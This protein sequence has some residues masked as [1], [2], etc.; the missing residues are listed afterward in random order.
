M[1]VLLY[2]FRWADES[3]CEFQASADNR[4]GR[5]KIKIGDKISIE[6]KSREKK[7]AGSIENGIWKACPKNS[8]GKSKCDYCR[9]I[10]GNFVYTAFD[11]FDQS[12]LGAGDLD[13]ISDT[14][15]I[16]LAF[17]AENLIKVGVSKNSRKNL[18]QIEQG[19]LA[20][21]FV[22]E[23]PDGIAARQIETILR[24]SGLADKIQ[25]AQK[26]KVFLSD[27]SAEEIAKFMN[28]KFEQH[29]PALDAHEHLREF[30]LKTPEFVSWE[31]TYNF[32]KIR[33]GSKP[34]HHIDLNEEEWVSGT[35]IS[36]RGPFITIET[37][38]EKIAICAKKLCGLEIDF[39]SKE[40]GLKTN[41]VMQGSLF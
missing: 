10:E 21:L 19:S 16:Y 35:I 13:K 17:F 3:S 7:C 5:K 24:Q 20:T 11:G 40:I 28:K 6:V 30:I 29:L 22:A 8:V 37:E 18:R 26:K 23:T 27:L 36:I 1:K 32:A 39:E 15:V 12:E 41:A 34:F 2:D 14:H 25:I 38:D 33:H 31:K 9:A 4:F